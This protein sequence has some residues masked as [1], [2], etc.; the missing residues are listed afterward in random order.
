[1][2]VLGNTFYFE[3]EVNLMVW[4]QSHLGQAGVLLANFFS[5]FG[6]ELLM[7][8]ILGF[9]YW[10]YDKKFGVYV[11]FNLLV[12]NLWNP[13]IKNIC[14]R[15]RPYMDNSEILCLRQ[16]DAEGDMYDVITQGYSF[17]S[18]HSTGAAALYGSIATYKKKK[19]I[20]IIA[21]SIILLVGISRFCLGV[22]YPTDVLVGWALG[23]I[24]ILIVPLMMKKIKKRWVVYSILLISGA[25]GFFY[26][27]STDYFT[28]Y[29]MLLGFAFAVPF[30][31]K[32]VNFE[33]TRSVIRSIL[34]IAGGS[35]IFFGLNTL[36]KLP[37]SSEFLSDGSTLSHVV[38]TLRYAIVL[39]I[40]M[41][42]YPLLFKATA[43]TKVGVKESA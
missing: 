37:F 1:M 23:F 3:W 28:S 6:E 8:A 11:G 21:Y 17:P 31:E 36:L 13:M 35:A 25:V 16:V 38:R 26:C 7:V 32:F 4:L 9:L 29:G 34:R 5:M 39:F 19:W 42:V 41:G 22:H 15:R 40:D 10:C 14:L 12:A 33:G 18:G 24:A 43:K 2:E 27:E 30:E 20:L